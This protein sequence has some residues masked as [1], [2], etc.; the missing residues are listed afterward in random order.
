VDA[1]KSGCGSK[2]LLLKD[3]FKPEG[4]YSQVLRNLAIVFRI[5]GIHAFDG[6]CCNQE[7]P[8]MRKG[9]GGMMR[10]GW[11]SQRSILS[12]HFMMMRRTEWICTMPNTEL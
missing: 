3:T 5:E 6:I 9:N 7:S 12:L 8:N 11:T 1:I 4:E 2:L 10:P